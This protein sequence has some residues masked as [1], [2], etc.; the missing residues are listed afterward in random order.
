MATLADSFLA[1]LDELSDNEAEIPADDG[2]DAADMDEDV[3]GDLADLENLNYDDL[4][5]VSKLQ[6]TQRYIDVIQGPFGLAYF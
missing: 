6:K 3:D 1:D 4:D 5:S 2:G